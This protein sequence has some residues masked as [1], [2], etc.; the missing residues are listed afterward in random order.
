MISAVLRTTRIMLHQATVPVALAGRASAS[1]FASVSAQLR[2]GSRPLANVL[3]SR[4]MRRIE[5]ES[6]E[7]SLESSHV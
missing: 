4:M 5:A 7:V 6:L 1:E 3:A 2:L